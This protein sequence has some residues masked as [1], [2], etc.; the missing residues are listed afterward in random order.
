M[1]VGLD[2]KK[3]IQGQW[4]WIK[5]EMHIFPQD[6]IEPKDYLQLALEG[7]LLASKK[8]QPILEPVLDRAWPSRLQEG[9]V[10]FA[11]GLINLEEGQISLDY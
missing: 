2:L 1:Q 8:L 11:D 10:N 6:S 9:P 7:S 5:S 4:E 3:D